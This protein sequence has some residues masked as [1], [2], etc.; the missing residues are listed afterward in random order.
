MMAVMLKL[1]KN[2][3]MKKYIMILLVALMTTVSGFAAAAHDV[4]AVFSEFAEADNATYVKVNPFMMWLSRAFV[5]G[6][7]AKIVRKV[8]SVRVL[9]M[10][11][12]SMTVK[13]RFKERV[14]ALGNGGLEEI[15]R[16]NDD[17]EHVRILAKVEKDEIRKMLVVCTSG[18]DCTLV[19]INGK[20]SM[21]DISGVIESQV[22]KHD[23]CK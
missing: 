20:F 11:D 23:G 8:K 17:G 1:Q 12:C 21:D 18:D 5:S 7:E 6:D 14:D 9:D 15:V 13:S 19:E 16:V 4:D 22:P 3:V 2:I 10:D